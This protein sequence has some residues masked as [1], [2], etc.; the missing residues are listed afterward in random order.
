MHLC[1]D[2]SCRPCRDAIAT[3]KLLAIWIGVGF[4]FQETRTVTATTA[5]PAERGISSVGL[6]VCG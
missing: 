5:W 1:G 4:T 3:I 2:R 6:T